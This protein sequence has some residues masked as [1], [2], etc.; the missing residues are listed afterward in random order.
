MTTLLDLPHPH[1]HPDPCAT[2]GIETEIEIAIAI[3]TAI[4]TDQARECQARG[5]RIVVDTTAIMIDGSP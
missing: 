3:A 5:V 4:V 2:T 1:L